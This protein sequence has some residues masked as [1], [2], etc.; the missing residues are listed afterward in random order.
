MDV[1]VF[2]PNCQSYKERDLNTVYSHHET[3][4]K[5]EYND[6]VLNVEHGT[7]TPLVFSTTGVGAK[8]LPGFTSTWPNS[9]QKRGMRTTTL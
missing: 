4:N 2:D 9:S 3:Q 1:R 5:N 8:R 6:R 7:L